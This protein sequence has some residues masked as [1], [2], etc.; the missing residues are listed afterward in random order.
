MTDPHLFD[1][2]AACLL[3]MPTQASFDACLEA[4]LGDGQPQDCLLLTGDLAQDHL[5]STYQRLGRQ[6]DGLELPWFWLPGNHDDAEA[7][8]AALGQPVRCLKGKH[9]QLVLLHSQV[10]GRVYGQLSDDELALLEHCLEDE[11]RH[12][13]VAV[14][15]HPLAVDSHW[16]DQH[17][18]NN[19]QTLLARLA[20][21]PKAAAVLYGHVHQER[22]QNVQGVRLLATPATCVQFAAGSSDFALAELGPGYRRLT[23][24]P[25]GSIHTRVYRL[26]AEQF[27]VDEQAG[28]Y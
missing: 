20:R 19:G 2:P 8:S 22:D 12:V 23:L 4:M 14:H 1:D 13:L 10:P 26:P 3:G 27:P 11:S 28:G 25:D 6:L 7:M 18:L 21:H 17:I 24:A 16:L 9:W 5:Q 15:H